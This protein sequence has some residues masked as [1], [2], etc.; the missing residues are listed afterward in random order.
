M[1]VSELIKELEK[2]PQDATVRLNGAR[3]YSVDA[4][5]YDDDDYE[6]VMIID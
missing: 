4:V 5:V 3:G 6:C 2:M 1:T